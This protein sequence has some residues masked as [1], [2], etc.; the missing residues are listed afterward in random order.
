[1]GADD[2]VNRAALDPLQGLASLGIGLESRQGRDLDREPRVSLGEG[3]EVLLHQKGSW[4][5]H[6]HLFAVLDGLEGS[7]HRD[8]SLA[9][10]DVA[11][12]QAVHRDDLFHVVLDV[13]DGGELIRGL[14]VGE[15]VL[16]LPLPGGVG[17]EGVALGGLPGGIEFDEFSGDLTDCLAG[18]GLALAPVG[19]THPVQA[20]GITTDV[21]GHLVQRVDGDEETVAGLTLLGGGVLDDEVLAGSTTDGALHHLHVSAHTVLLMDDEVA[22]LKLKRLDLIATA[23][24]HAPLATDGW[25]LGISKVP[26]GGHQQFEGIRGET[27]TLMQPDDLDTRLGDLGIDLVNDL[28]CHVVFTEQLRHALGDAFTLGAQHDR[29]ALIESAGQILDGC[30]D[31]STPRL[32]GLQMRVDGVR[33]TRDH[34]VVSK[35]IRSGGVQGEGGHRPPCHAALQAVGPHVSQAAVAGGCQVDGGLTTPCGCRPPSPQELLGGANQVCGSG[36]HH[37][38][39]REDDHGVLREDVNEKLHLVNECG[40][41]SFHPLDSLTVGD[42]LQ[43]VRQLGVVR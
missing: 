31:V 26:G 39:V 3:L 13:G 22:G 24:G 34:V 12:D 10:T 41:E 42:P 17:A 1:M 40:H 38:G 28:G 14:D 16:Q 8:L 30:L 32:D 20:G 18:S 5:Q 6:G 33:G 21:A 36:S 27:V 29:P 23:S 19:A 43:H 15:G 37:F 11:T 9:V 35:G 25:S 2:D 7:A 4:H